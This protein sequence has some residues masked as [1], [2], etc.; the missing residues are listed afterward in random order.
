MFKKKI[1]KKKKKI[2]E[3]TL[4][5]TCQSVP[6]TKELG[7]KH[8]TLAIIKQMATHMQLPR[9]LKPSF[10]MKTYCL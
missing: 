3:E 9:C 5:P 2:E 7:R 4:L 10:F 8:R 1:V 6:T